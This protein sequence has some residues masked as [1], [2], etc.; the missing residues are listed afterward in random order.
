MSLGMRHWD[1]GWEYK[2]LREK[3][4]K[5]APFINDIPDLTAPLIEYSNNLNR[6]VDLV[7]KN[8]SQIVLMTQ[9]TLWSRDLEPKAQKL[10]W[11][12]GLGNFLREKGKP[13]YSVAVLEQA[14]ARYNQKLLRIC[15]SR[16]IRC[17]DLASQVPKSLDYFYD[18]AHLNNG[19]ARR[20]ARTISGFLLGRK[21]FQD[22]RLGGA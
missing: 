2:V 3:R 13:Y 16:K 6:I 21:P 15:E 4:Q 12:G 1:G 7:Q 22:F 14:M 20:V 5:A 18:D 9:P 10:L 17:I 11:F 8:G 19:G